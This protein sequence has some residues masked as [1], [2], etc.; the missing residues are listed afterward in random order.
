VHEELFFK[1]N[2]HEGLTNKTS[3]EMRKNHK[4]LTFNQKKNPRR[5]RKTLGKSSRAA[6]NSFRRSTTWSTYLSCKIS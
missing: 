2:M 1:K 3:S 6:S 4:I 5:R